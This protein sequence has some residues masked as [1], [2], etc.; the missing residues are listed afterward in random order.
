M[1]DVEYR[2][3]RELSVAWAAG[4]LD[5]EGCITLGKPSGRCDNTTRLVIVSAV[6]INSAPLVQLGSLFGGVPRP[7]RVNAK[8]QTIHQW[9]ISS[10]DYVI[11][12]LEEI[13]P[14]LRVK[15]PEAD[16]VL[17]YARTM[18]RGQKITPFLRICRRQ[19]I[20]RLAVIREGV[21]T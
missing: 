17:A 16:V 11:R 15:G 4:F 8:G 14:Y 21:S 20:N 13:N 6:Q 7:M 3:R 12:C 1:N 10:A 18:K 5:G 2:E 19:L 9:S